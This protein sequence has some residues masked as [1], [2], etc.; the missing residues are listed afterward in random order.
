MLTKAELLTAGNWQG[1]AVPHP[2]HAR[3]LRLWNVTD[4][5]WSIL[6]LTVN[7]VAAV[8]AASDL[9]EKFVECN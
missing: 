1:L 7:E 3:S 6:F 8:H 2:C 5:K 9:Q 4:L